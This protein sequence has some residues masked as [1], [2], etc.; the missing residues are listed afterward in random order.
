MTNDQGIS[1]IKFRKDAWDR[2]AGMNS[3]SYPFDADV[4]SVDEEGFV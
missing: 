2:V 4:G 1:N 3:R